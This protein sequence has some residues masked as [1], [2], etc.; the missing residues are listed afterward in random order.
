VQDLS[1]PELL[2]FSFHCKPD[3]I[4]AQWTAKEESRKRRKTRWW[5]GKAVKAG[6]AEKDRATAEP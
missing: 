3:T 4:A 1:R 2:C 6:K 5:S